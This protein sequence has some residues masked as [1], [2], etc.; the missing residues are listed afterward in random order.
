[1]VS[2]MMIYNIVALVRFICSDYLEKQR[3][4][5]NGKL[6]GK[7]DMI[8]GGLAWLCIVVGLLTFNLG[9]WYFGFHYFKCSTEMEAM[10]TRMTMTVTE[11][12]KLL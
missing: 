7:K 11:H 4:L 3:E 12:S 10:G 5:Q 6:I 9:N 2:C 1:M 8:I